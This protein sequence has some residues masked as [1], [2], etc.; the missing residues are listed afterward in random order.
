M[1]DHVFGQAGVDYYIE[2]G[3]MVVSSR[4]DVHTHLEMRVYDCR[5]LMDLPGRTSRAA[6][7]SGI[8]GSPGEASSAPAAA[9]APGASPDRSDAAAVAAAG[10]DAEFVKLLQGSVKPDSWKEAGGPG[11]LTYYRGLLIIYQSAPA[12]RE[13][14]QFLE[15]IRLA[16]TKQSQPG[17][18]K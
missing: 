7:D 16:V 2:D 10:G 6:I 4:E 9:S 18:N 17:K 8:G 14:D 1:L 12:H 5:D 3:T 13:I 11:S 15:K